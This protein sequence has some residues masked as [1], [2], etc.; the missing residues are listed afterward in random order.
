MS[1]GRPYQERQNTPHLTSALYLKAGTLRDEKH[2]F[3][4]F[5]NQG[6]HLI[7]LFHILPSEHSDRAPYKLFLKHSKKANYQ[8]KRG[9]MIDKV[10]SAP[11]TEKEEEKK[12][13]YITMKNYS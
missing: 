11:P 8:H 4:P 2:L 3:K 10:G 12:N 9:Q 7:Q 6:Q 13:Q 5:L 1:N